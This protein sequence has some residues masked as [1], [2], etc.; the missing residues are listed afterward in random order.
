LNRLGVEVV[1]LTGDN[2]GTAQAVAGEAGIARFEAEVLPGDKAAA[3]KKLKGPAA[4]SAWPA[5]AST[6]HRRWPRPTSA[7]PWP[8]A[9]TWRCRPPT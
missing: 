4:W 5:T 6:T 2:A 7:S 1:M 9:P 3:V 8:R